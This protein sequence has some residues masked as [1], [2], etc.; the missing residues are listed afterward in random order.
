MGSRP[1]SSV[2]ARP[3]AKCAA[4][5]SASCSRDRGWR[6]E[7]PQSSVPSSSSSDGSRLPI[8][9]GLPF[10]PVRLRPN[11]FHVA[12]LLR[13]LE[14]HVERFTHICK[15]SRFAAQQAWGCTFS[16]VSL[17]AGLGAFCSRCSLGAV[18]LSP[19]VA[20]GGLTCPP[21]RT[22]IFPIGCRLKEGGP[23]GVGLLIVMLQ[24]STLT[25]RVCVCQDPL[26][27]RTIARRRMHPQD[28]VLG[29]T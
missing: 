16:V 10:A 9:R 17:L 29:A 15:F 8:F 20:L 12:G 26:S 23:G 11:C 28:M 22:R 19:V 5:A 6:M 2:R 21:R 4:R 27:V 13:R 1:L 24:E 7:S 14:S 25:A 3:G 18:V